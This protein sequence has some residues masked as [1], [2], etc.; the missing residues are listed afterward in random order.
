MCDYFLVSSRF[1]SAV[2]DVKVRLQTSLLT[3]H[4]LVL[5]IFQL[6]LKAQK[7]V[8]A[9]KKLDIN[10]LSL[11]HVRNQLK[12]ELRS[13][14]NEMSVVSE[15][16]IAWEQAEKSLKE[17][18]E[19]VLGFKKRRRTDG[20]ISNHSQQ[21]SEA[22][23]A[24]SDEVERKKLAKSLRRSL[25][26]DEMVYWCGIAAEMEVAQAAGN[27][28][29]LFGVLKRV[30]GKHSGVSDT[31]LDEAGQLILNKS[32]RL[33]RWQ[34]YFESLLNRPPPPNRDEELRVAAEHA[35]PSPTISCEPPSDAEIR[36]VIMSLKNG[37][38]AGPDGIPAELYKCGVDE[39]LPFLSQLIRKAWVG[40]STPKKWQQSLLVPVFKKGD[41]K[42]CSNYRGISFDTDRGQSLFV[43][44]HGENRAIFRRYC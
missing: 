4:K 18:S 11:P 34:K 23:R 10:R 25:R 32:E 13:K 3:D 39:I 2:Q 35:T 33:P 20:F 9:L 7:S 41:A 5:G 28:K 21:I 15:L 27:S 42:N 1:F 30:L 37:K 40:G 29:A 12:N 38:A 8:P 22:R 16:D 36:R 14:F 17:T 26:R 19:A 43:A 31:I 24:T 44:N 6:R